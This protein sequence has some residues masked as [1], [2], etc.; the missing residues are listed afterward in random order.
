M[1]TMIGI[2][3]MVFVVLGGL[4]G[5]ASYYQVKDP[6]A[7]KV[8]YTRSIDEERGGAIKFEDEKTGSKITLQNSEVKKIER[9]EYRQAVEETDE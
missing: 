6:T 3:L 8:Y 4:T 2:T 5:C 7:D 9:K 1:R